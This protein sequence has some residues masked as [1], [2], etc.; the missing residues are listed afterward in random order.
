MYTTTYVVF[1]ASNA[2]ITSLR[3]D[4]LSIRS[5]MKLHL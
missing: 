5:V 4:L 3:I 2:I 1:L